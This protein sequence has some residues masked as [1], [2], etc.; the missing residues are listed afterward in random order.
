MRRAATLRPR[1]V[2]HSVKENRMLTPRLP[3][4]ALVY[5]TLAGLFLLAACAP[6]PAAPAPTAA[7]AAQT[8]ANAA[9]KAPVKLEF[10]MPWILPT[11][12]FYFLTADQKG[13]YRDEGLEVHLNEGSGSGNAV[14]IVGAGSTPIG[15]ADANRILAG[16]VNGVPVK[17]IMSLFYTSPV[18]VVSPAD[19][20]I[21]SLDG[22]VGKKLGDAPDSANLLIW[23]AAMK[24]KGVDAEQVNFINVDP[25][26]KNQLLL[27]GQIDAA[28]SQSD[29]AD[30]EAEGHPMYKLSVTEDSGFNIVADSIFA[31]EDFLNKNPDVVRAFLRATLKGADYTRQHPDEAIGFAQKVAPTFTQKQLEAQYQLEDSWIWNKFTPADKFGFQQVDSWNNLQDLLFDNKQIDKKI[32]MKE[33]VD[34]SYLPYK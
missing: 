4:P 26:A 5:L 15:M 23:R 25:K 24:R 7:G 18:L 20:P 19:K 28:L 10:A 11:E 22:L 21:K 30:L 13:F 14:K 27:A 12:Y 33:L 29:V 16:R 8:S 17:S 1:A 31:N 34:N 6:A 32:D 2:V 3:R 9:T